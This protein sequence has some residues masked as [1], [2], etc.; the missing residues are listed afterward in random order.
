MSP[1]EQVRS[2]V[3]QLNSTGDIVVTEQEFSTLGGGLGVG[4]DWFPDADPGNAI[5]GTSPAGR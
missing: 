1:A 5:P 3:Q 2:F 4:L